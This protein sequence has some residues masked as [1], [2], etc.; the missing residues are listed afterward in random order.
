MFSGW[1]VSYLSVIIDFHSVIISKDNWNPTVVITP[2]D[3]VRRWLRIYRAL[4]V[5]AR[6]NHSGSVLG[7]LNAWCDC[8]IS[9]RFAAFTIHQC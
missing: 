2:E 3:Y 5:N 9:L 7:R 8:F 1:S 4:N 6:S